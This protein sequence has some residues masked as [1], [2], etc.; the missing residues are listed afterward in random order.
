MFKNLPN[1]L[2]NHLFP[3]VG[4]FNK[5]YF[6]LQFTSMKIIPAFYIIL[7]NRINKKIK[8]NTVVIESS[9]GNFAYGLALIC[10]YLKIKLVIVGD[11]GIDE[12]LCNKLKLLNTK[13]IIVGNSKTKNIQSLRLKILN[14]QLL[15]YKNHFWPQQY[16][17]PDNINSY[18]ILKNFLL[19]KIDLKNID[20]VVCAV[21]S[22]GSSAGFYKL[23]SKFNPKIELIGVDSVNSVIF[24]NSLGKRYLRGPGSSIYPKNVKYNLFTKIFWVKD[25]EAYTQGLNLFKETG[26]NSSPCVGAVHLVSNYLNVNYKNKKILAIFPETGERYLKTMYNMNWLRKKK[27]FI[28]KINKPQK[29]KFLSEDLKRFS[30]FDW[31]KM[32]F[33]NK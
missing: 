15:K 11:R 9:S 1:F 30:Y 13:V 8:K 2:K 32:T 17:N 24:G 12:D 26:I 22:G 25:S 27:L 10:N 19:K 33:K 18:K 14:K 3:S 20:I 5:N 21:G 16:D 23:I 4:K 6:F 29:K 31:N 7:K 28:N